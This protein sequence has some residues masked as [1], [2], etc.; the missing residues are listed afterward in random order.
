MSGVAS[1]VVKS[2]DTSFSCLVCQHCEC[3][4]WFFG[5]GVVGRTMPRY[6]LFGDTVNLASR[7]ESNSLRNFHEFFRHTEP[8][9][10][11]CD[12]IAT[13]LWLQMHFGSPPTNVWMFQRWRFSW[14]RERWRLW[15]VSAATSS[16]HVVTLT[17]RWESLD[18]V[19]LV[20][21]QCFEVQF[22]C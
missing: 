15:R 11:T 21:K 10:N 8:W 4:M 18:I 1:V 2:S 20:S 13:R 16:S 7:M 19:Y 9:S 6:C 5:I 3:L 22:M 17:L 14:A 12:R